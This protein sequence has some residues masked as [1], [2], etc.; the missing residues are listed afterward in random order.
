MCIRDRVHLAQGD[1]AAALTALET[2]RQQL[3]EKGWEDERLQAMVLQAL[4]HQAHG[5]MATAVDLLGEAL[6]LAEPGGFI[7]IFVDEGSPMRRLLSEATARAAMP[8]Y[9][10]NLLAAFETEA[11][12]SPVSYTHLRAHETDSYLV[13]R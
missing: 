7:R 2:L 9:T 1:P 11:P 10:G 12:P 3:K 13:C 5:D 8:D 6:A 4:A